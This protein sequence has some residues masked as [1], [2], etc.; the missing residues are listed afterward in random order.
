M[1]ASMIAPV[2]C[3]STSP[4]PPPDLVSTGSAPSGEESM[5]ADS[6]E[7][8]SPTPWQDRRVEVTFFSP[9]QKNIIKKVK[10]NVDLLQEDQPF[11]QW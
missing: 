7:R 11:G 8:L 1:P 4:A 5:P 2:E 9:V 10:C 6:E 3:L